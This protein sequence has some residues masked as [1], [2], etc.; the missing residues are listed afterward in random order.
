MN[1]SGSCRV[2]QTSKHKIAQ[3]EK[4]LEKLNEQ[5]QHCTLCPRNCGVDRINGQVGYCQLSDKIKIYKYKLHF[6]E[7]P[8]ISGRRG[9]GIIFFSGCTMGCVFCQNYPMSHLRQGYEISPLNL[10]KIMIE[11]QSQ[12]AHNIN[13]VTPTHFLTPILRS[14]QLAIEHGLNLP[15]VYNTNGYEN[16]EILKT[17]AGI[18]D[19]YLPDMKYAESVSARRYSKTK[20]YPETNFPA[21]KEMFRQVGFLETD[22]NNLAKKGLIIRHLILPNDLAG[23]E[24]IFRFI[25]REISEQVHLS[26]MTQYLPIWEAKKY[27]EIDRRINHHEY[28]EVIGLMEKYNLKTGWLQEMEF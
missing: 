24:T 19:V 5:M 26:L 1:D 2:K 25:A 13:L 17:L 15:I 11:L 20:N 8:P 3:I 27:P 16:I 4:A 21:V 28:A 22:E 6:G 10:A 7:E 9:S 14:L 18:I 23:T 12:G